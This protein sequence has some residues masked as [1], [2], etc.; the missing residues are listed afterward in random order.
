VHR[1]VGLIL[2]L[3]TVSWSQ[4]LSDRIILLIPKTY[5]MYHQH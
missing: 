2:V 3:I 5:F 1:A 4:S